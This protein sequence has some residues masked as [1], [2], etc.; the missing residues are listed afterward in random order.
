MRMT[1]I[2]QSAGEAGGLAAPLRDVVRSIDASLPVFNL[3]TVATLY[4][5]RV[6]GTW[7]QLFQLVGT[8][9]FIGLA[10]ATSGLYGL[11]LYTVSRRVQELGIRVALGASRRDVVWLVERRGLM[12]AGLGISAGAALTFALGPMLAAGFPGL[13][14]TSPAAYVGVAILLLAVC[15][16]ASYAPARRAASADPLRALRNE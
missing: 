1:L 11:V 6:T 10:L 2:A 13:G 9:G 14:V 7:M 12:L 8:L 3:R 15:A 4:D 5:S 16:A